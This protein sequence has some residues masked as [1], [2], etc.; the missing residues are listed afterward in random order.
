MKKPPIQPRMNGNMSPAKNKTVTGKVLCTKT[1]SAV[2]ESEVQTT[3]P[4]IKEHQTELHVQLQVEWLV[5]HS[6]DGG[7]TGGKEVKG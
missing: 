2:Q 3:V 7:G 5:K 1:C 4:K 6:E